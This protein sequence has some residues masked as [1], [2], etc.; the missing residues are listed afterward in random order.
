MTNQNKLTWAEK[1]HWAVEYNTDVIK[2]I[3]EL[4]QVLDT[5]KSAQIRQLTADKQYWIDKANEYQQK[6]TQSRKPWSES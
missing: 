2:V 5:G 1:I 3:D 6:W 4:T